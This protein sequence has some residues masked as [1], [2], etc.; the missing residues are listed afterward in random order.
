MF[1]RIDS[2]VLFNYFVF[3]VSGKI[4]GFFLNLQRYNR[5]GSLSIGDILRGIGNRINNFVF[6]YGY[7]NMI[8]FIVF[9][10]SVNQ[11]K[12]PK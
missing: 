11:T 2:W 1:V 3:L 9:L 4:L 7:Q 12:I 10:P 8:R 5:I 6:S